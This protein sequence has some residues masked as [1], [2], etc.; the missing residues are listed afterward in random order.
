MDD[1]EGRQPYQRAGDTLAHPLLSAN[2]NGFNGSG[3]AKERKHWH[4]WKAI[5][6]E[7][8]NQGH[9]GSEAP[10]QDIQKP[11]TPP[12][13]QSQQTANGSQWSHKAEIIYPP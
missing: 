11:K 4:Q 9:A 10:Q 6:S 3:P 12:S 5:A 7:D 8:I 2:G 1:H 13:L